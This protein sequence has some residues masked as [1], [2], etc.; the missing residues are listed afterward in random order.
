VEEQE[1]L[2]LLLD[3]YLP[4]LD[5]LPITYKLKIQALK[6]KF[7]PEE[8]PWIAML[9]NQCPTGPL[10]LNRHL[11]STNQSQEIQ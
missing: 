3:R 5:L 11:G 8:I 10:S 6:F 4:L 9:H 7:T 2:H 1:M